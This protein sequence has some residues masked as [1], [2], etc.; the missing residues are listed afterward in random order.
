MRIVG[1]IEDPQLKITVFQMNNR[2]SVKI[3]YRLMEQTYKLPLEF[4]G[5]TLQNL[6]ERFSPELR[7]QIISTFVKMAENQMHFLPSE[8]EELDFPYIL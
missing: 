7:E 3:E 2:V 1:Y 4:T 6:K 8:D 5:Q